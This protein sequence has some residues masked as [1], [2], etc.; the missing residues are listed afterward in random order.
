MI[1]KESIL[2]T[3]TSSGIGKNTAVMLAQN[4]Y[5]IIAGV[6]KEEDFKTLEKVHQNIK[7]IFL[8]VLSKQSLETAYKKLSDENIELIGIINNAGA[9]VAQPVECINID[10]L[11]Y[12]FELNT[13]A[14]VAVTQTFLPLMKK[15]KI[16]NISSMASTGIFPYIAPYCASK[17]A[18]DILFNSLS[19]EFKNKN[20]KIVSIKPGSIKTPIWNKSISN[21]K[22]S[23]DNIDEKFKQKYEKD[24]NFL[25]KNAEKNN[26]KALDTEKVSKTILKVLKTK[27]SKSSY[28]VGIDSKIACL[29]SKLPQDLLNKIILCQLK[30]KLK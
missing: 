12:Q 29:I 9:V 4:G 11:K 17:R 27:N 25:A 3:G 10:D 21:N 23:L 24:M 1:M 15:G 19:L 8:D 22:K 6:R 13:I 16:I 18:M 14:P 28:C 20:I 2:I 7:P 30:K 26:Y 5:N